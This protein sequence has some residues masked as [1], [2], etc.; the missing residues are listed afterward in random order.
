M[1]MAGRWRKRTSEVATIGITAARSVARPTLAAPDTA[2]P[3]A[4]PARRARS[5][6]GPLNA[7]RIPATPIS[8]CPLRASVGPID[9]EH[10]A[11]RE[12]SRFDQV[13]RLVR[14]AVGE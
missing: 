4:G 7:Q 2:A 1:G 13:E 9:L 14:A 3:P 8:R 10:Y 11:L 6:I 12:G 5:R